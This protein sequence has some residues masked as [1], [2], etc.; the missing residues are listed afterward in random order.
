MSGLV[1]M[2]D[3]IICNIHELMFLNM[4]QFGWYNTIFIIAI[5]K[6]YVG[7]A[8]L[9]C[10]SVCSSFNKVVLPAP[11]IN[12]KKLA[13]KKHFF[14]S[15]SCFIVLWARF[16]KWDLARPR[17][18]MLSPS[19]SVPLKYYLLI[20]KKKVNEKVNAIA[21]NSSILFLSQTI[22]LVRR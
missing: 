15:L 13:I 10:F 21:F 11:R 5:F 14:L 19:S 16:W 20:K 2:L 4:L 3:Y 22:Y 9:H 8:K 6:V 1:I 7:T 18:H 17:H 12:L